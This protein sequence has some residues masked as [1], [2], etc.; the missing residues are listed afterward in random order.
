M[1]DLAAQRPNRRA[2]RVDES[3]DACRWYRKSKDAW[4]QLPVRNSVAPNGF[5]VTEFAAVSAK[6]AQCDQGLP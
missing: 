5:K 6:L 3:N 2:A 4:M 1:G